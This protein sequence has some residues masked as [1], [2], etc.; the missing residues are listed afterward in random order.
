MSFYPNAI[1]PGEGLI[2]PMDDSTARL[3]Y[4]TV[5]TGE[6]K[7]VTILITA[8][9]RDA[10]GGQPYMDVR[11]ADDRV[12]LPGNIAHKYQSVQTAA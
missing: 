7:S 5:T 9:V 12:I 1:R 4:R 8:E 10:L 11:M 3:I 6:R 2:V